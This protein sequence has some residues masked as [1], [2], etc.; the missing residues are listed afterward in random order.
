MSERYKTIILLLLVF[1]WSPQAGFGKSQRAV[2]WKE[3][4]AFEGQLVQEMD[5]EP[6]KKFYKLTNDLLPPIT[7]NDAKYD[8][9]PVVFCKYLSEEKTSYVLFLARGLLSIPGDS[10][11]QAYVFDESGNIFWRNN[12]SL[13]RRDDFI[14]ANVIR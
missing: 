14:S 5:E 3:F 2:V 11:G 10:R 6:R 13:G 8:V 9:S 12:F 7:S 4:I 1:S